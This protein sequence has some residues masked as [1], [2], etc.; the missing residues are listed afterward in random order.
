MWN[1]PH[2]RHADFVGRRDLLDALAPTGS[3]ATGAAR[4]ITGPGGVGKT[5]LAVEYAYAHR[6]EFD[7]VWWV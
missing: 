4:A 2:D 7:V 6:D 5:Q 3:P 1:V